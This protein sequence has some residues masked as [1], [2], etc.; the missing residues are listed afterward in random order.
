VLHFLPAHSFDFAV[1]F[2]VM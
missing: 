1:F 2:C